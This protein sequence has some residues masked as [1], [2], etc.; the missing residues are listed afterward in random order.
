MRFGETAFLRWVYRDLASPRG[1]LPALFSPQPAEVALPSDDRSRALIAF[2]RHRNP[3]TGAVWSFAEER[4]EGELMG[5]LYQE[6]DPVVKDRFAL[7]QTPDFVRAFILDRTLTPA[8]ET[9][10]ANEVRLLDPACGSGHF[11]IDGLK[12]LVAATA[13]HHPDWA[14][15]KVVLHAL[16]RVVGRLESFYRGG[17]GNS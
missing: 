17:A 11:L 9:F 8:I 15:E 10:G 3:D 1:G 7:C 13:A 5:D 16:D 12:R 4:F 14:R 6:L 2:W